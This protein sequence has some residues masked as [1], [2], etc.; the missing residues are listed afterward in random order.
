[1]NKDNHDDILNDYNNWNGVLDIDNI[2]SIEKLMTLVDEPNELYKILIESEFC[3]KSSDYHYLMI[4]K[5]NP[6]YYLIIKRGINPLKIDDDGNYFGSGYR[7]LF[8]NVLQY[9]EQQDFI[10]CDENEYKNGK[11]KIIREFC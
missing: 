8:P 2:D 7:V 1:M 3:C 9:Y 11:Y 5:L 4:D 10:Q 6:L